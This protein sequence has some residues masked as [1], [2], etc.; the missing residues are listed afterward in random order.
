MGP[1]KVSRKKWELSWA[2]TGQFLPPSTLSLNPGDNSHSAAVWSTVI[3]PRQCGC[4]VLQMCLV[5]TEMVLG[6]KWTLDFE[7]SIK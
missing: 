4:E 7:V 1:E 3:A 6:I 5:R 2:L